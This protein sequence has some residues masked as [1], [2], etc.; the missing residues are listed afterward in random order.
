MRRS[1][2]HV[3]ARALTALGAMALVLLLA[4]SNVTA[5][6]DDA[7]FDLMAGS[8]KRT[9]SSQLVVVTI[10]PESLAQHGPWP[11]PRRDLARLVDQLSAAG[12]RAVG[13]QLLLAQDSLYDPQGDA[14]LAQAMTRNGAVVLPVIADLSD[15]TQAATALLPAQ[16]LIDAAAALGHTDAVADDRG[17]ARRIA[18]HAGLG[19]PQW[20]AFALALRDVTSSRA[21][22]DSLRAAR[23]RGR[24]A[25]R[26]DIAASDDHWVRAD[27]V[28]VAS[29]RIT[30]DIVHVTA[31]SVLSGQVGA[32]L[33]GGRIA[34]IGRTDL[35]A[36]Q[37]LSLPG[38]PNSLPLVDFQA[39]AL[40]RLLEDRA[41]WPMPIGPQVLLSVILVTL[42][43]LLLGLPGLR[44][45]WAPMGVA[46]TLVLLVSWT[47]LLAGAWFPPF[48][49][50]VVLA[51]GL[52]IGTASAW[53]RIRQ[54]SFTDLA[55]GVANRLCFDARLESDTRRARRN[56]QPLSLLL[57]EARGA[58]SQAPGSESLATTL[59]AG[60]RLRAQ[61]PR[62]LVARLDAVR[63]AALL[64][65]TAP[66]VAA[67][68]A[69][70]LMVDLEARLGQPRPGIT[71]Q[72]VRMGLASLKAEDSRGTDLLLRATRDLVTMRDPTA[73]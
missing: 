71:V 49:A 15:G 40:A 72:A 9:G 45:L 12:T 44:R 13:L 67:A 7:L 39:N 8:G 42:P 66:H 50:L 17:I 43:L 22:R 52:A 37:R 23:A 63:F 48:P 46:M 73:R 25:P 10:D 36:E 24:A 54:R 18:L 60:L 41:I 2:A 19:S 6:L 35:P 47:L 31:A 33:L 64:P 65:G 32:S 14:L 5:P 59:A 28:L 55:T 21:S 69:T 3:G 29:P 34:I 53:R 1:P 61:R 20:P 56:G 62:D 27:T 57:V 4:L 38:A 11:W 58:A 51:V 30:S 16:V 70:A 68:L 26:L